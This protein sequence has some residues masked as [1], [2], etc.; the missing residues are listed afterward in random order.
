[1]YACDSGC[2]H[3]QE[4]GE[5]V[6]TRA[7]IVDNFMRT[8]IMVDNVHL[9]NVTSLVEIQQYKCVS[10]FTFL[11]NKFVATTN[12]SKEVD[13]LSGLFARHRRIAPSSNNPFKSNNDKNLYFRKWDEKYFSVR[14]FYGL[15]WHGCR[16]EWSI[17]L[18]A[19]SSEYC[20]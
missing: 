12:W 19:P 4:R 9:Q 3:P 8:Y 11:Y 7:G 20:V 1:M 18:T 13:A 17:H 16:T 5:P 6:R 14:V 15:W 10:S 2:T